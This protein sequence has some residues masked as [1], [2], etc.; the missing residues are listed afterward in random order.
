MEEEVAVIVMLVQMPTW[1]KYFDAMIHPGR[2]F[3]GVCLAR[4]ALAVGK[5]CDVLTDTTV[6]FVCCLQRHT[7]SRLDGFEHICKR[8][9]SAGRC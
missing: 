1:K 9:M 3:Q 8:E 2:T 4:S 5:D 6:A 7:H